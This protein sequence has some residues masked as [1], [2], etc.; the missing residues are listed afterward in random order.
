MGKKRILVV[1][2]DQST[3]ASLQQI[4]TKQ[5]YEV[6]LAGDGQAA[7]DRYNQEDPD[8]VL[9]EAMLSKIHGF[10]LCQRITSVH[11][12]RVPV[13]IMTGVYKD[14]VYR[15]EALRSYGASEYFEKPLKIAEILASI[16]AVIGKPA[17]DEPE[18]EPAPDPDLDPG[19]IEAQAAA[20]AMQGATVAAEASR[21]A[22]P[23]PAADDSG[24]AFDLEQLEKDIPKIMADTPAPPSK[25]KQASAA[26]AADDLVAAALK[27]LPNVKVEPAAGPNNNGHDGGEI[28]NILKSALAD[29]DLAAKKKKAPAPK[30]KVAA[31]ARVERPKP[32][33]PPEAPRKPAP[34]QP[35][36]AAKAAPSVARPAAAPAPKAE[37]V[38]PPP[39]P[40]APRPPQPPRAVEQPRVAAPPPPPPAP[41]ERAK[42]AWT[43]APPAPSPA[44]RPDPQP[45]Q[46]KEKAGPSPSWENPAPAEPPDEL[47]RSVIEDAKLRQRI[48][49]G[50]FDEVH[51]KKKARG[52]PPLAI[53]GAAVVVLALAGFLL[54]RPKPQPQPSRPVSPP[55]KAAAVIPETVPE[56]SP[57]TSAPAPV[58]QEPETK[59]APPAAKKTTDNGAADKTPPPSKKAA[60]TPA[61]PPAA[62][63]E[64]TAAESSEDLIAPIIQPAAN[65]ALDLQLA[66]DPKPEEKKAEIP[67]AKTVPEEVAGAA[68][69]AAEAAPPPV[70][71]TREGDLIDLI[72]VDVQPKVAKRVEPVYPQ[73]ALRLGIEGTI[74]VNALVDEKGDVVETGILRGMKDDR[75]LEKA[76]Q[77]AVKK[78]K[79]DPARKNGVNVKVWMPVVIVFKLGDGVGESME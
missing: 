12:R 14:R 31:S 59:P 69:E 74:T 32:A 22:K 39:R 60:Q 57:E 4:L 44:P 65:P 70:A 20:A 66:D 9:M 46:R 34:P 72:E 7:W 52:I 78:W 6:I 45:D 24:W 61:P 43:P 13:F 21:S 33:A 75:G 35:P 19:Y 23:K 17:A 26:A 3:L 41:V 11:E 79:F 67:P 18:P 64:E 56:Q 5:G 50:L 25:K 38:K 62:K 1:D 37:Y 15:T 68:A 51:E 10:E 55:A 71:A 48:P 2:Y 40:E 16:E 36:P 58:Q 27:S 76:A 47:R 54:F 73:G 30:P 49:T 42:P 8:L 53:G 28:D 29:L 63:A 77:T